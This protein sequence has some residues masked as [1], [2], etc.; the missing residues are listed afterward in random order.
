[1]S[2]GLPMTKEDAMHVARLRKRRVFAVSAVALAVVSGAVLVPDLLARVILNTID[3]VLMMSADRRQVTVTGPISCSETQP[4]DLR[5][6]VTQRSTGA[7]AQ[8][9]VRTFCT[10]TEQH[11]EVEA[12]VR[13]KETFEEG[14]ARAVAVALTSSGQTIDDAHQWLVDV[15][16]TEE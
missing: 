1:M 16:L 3:P 14:T 2:D 9:H 15:T 8:G 5:V 7:I 11:W 4:L 12:S 13:G 6:T 10:A